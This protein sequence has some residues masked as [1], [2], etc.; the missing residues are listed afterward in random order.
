MDLSH[1]GSED[2]SL[3]AISKPSFFE[4]IS[5]IADSSSDSTISEIHLSA[6]VS[7]AE[8][9]ISAV[10]EINNTQT[11]FESSLINDISAIA[12][13]SEISAILEISATEIETIVVSKSTSA[14]TC[15]HFKK[16]SFFLWNKTE[17]Y[18]YGG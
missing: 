9:E 8:N 4:D 1:Q 11:I 18:E 17:R 14:K 6:Q 2:S 13:I 7:Q 15:S 10:S 16:H 5:S 3:Q 12:D